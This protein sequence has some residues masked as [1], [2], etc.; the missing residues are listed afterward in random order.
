MRTPPQD[1]NWAQRITAASVLMAVLAAPI[2]FPSCGPATGPGEH[3]D[4]AGYPESEDAALMVRPA[5]PEIDPEI[6]RDR[7]FGEAPML[8]RQVAREELPPVAERLPENPLV[9]RPFN[10]IGRYGGS[11]RRA[12]LGE[13]TG[14]TGIAKT[15]NENLLGYRRPRGE[16]IDPNLAESFQVSEDGRA[17]TFRLRNGV[18]WSDGVPFTIEDILFWYYD[19]I[20]DTNANQYGFIS[21]DWVVAGK[22][23]RLEKIDEHTLKVSADGPMGTMLRRLCHHAFALPKH[24]FAPFHPRYNEAANYDDFKQRTTYVKLVMDPAVPRIS[25]WVPKEW[26]H[27]QYI[28]YERNPYYW[29]VDTMGNQLPYADGLTFSVIQDPQL[30]LLKFTNGE[31][32]LIGRNVNIDFVPTLRATAENREFTIYPRM[33]QSGPALYLNWDAQNTMLRK[34]VRNR[35]VREALSIAINREEINRIVYYGYLLPGGSAFSPSSPYY[36]QEVFSRNTQ[37]EPDRSRALLAE[38]GYGD[39]DGDGFREFGNGKRFALTIDMALGMG[40]GDLSELVRD[41]WQQVGIRVY[42]NP[43]RE[44]IIYSRRLNGEFEVYL[45]RSLAAGEEPR[46]SPQHWAILA[47]NSPFWH[48]NAA[49]EAPPWLREVTGIMNSALTTVDPEK[50]RDRLSRLQDLYVENIPFIGIGALALPWAASNRL[51]N[52]PETGNFAGASQGWS[53]PVFH[54]QLFLRAHA[55]P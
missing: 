50:A 25:A 55:Q 54:E 19:V 6:I 48:R 4:Q 36:S 3:S 5:P 39:E 9:V 24:V 33:H 13:Y 20:L 47:P 1:Q 41:Y 38:A 27:G 34:A 12:I 16:A 53:R 45:Y 7:T 8:A 10:E 18:K 40:L 15:L 51:G 31:I 29:K 22:P 42:L 21:S 46:N 14:W 11:I 23:V 30:I 2:L 44:E 52:V 28:V 17:M 49:S 35:K 32:D 37:Y 26:N 43:G